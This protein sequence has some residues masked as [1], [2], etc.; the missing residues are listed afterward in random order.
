MH[1]LFLFIGLTIKSC[2]T[3]SKIS[4]QSNHNKSSCKDLVWHSF[5]GGKPD[6]FYLNSSQKILK[7]GD[8]KLFMSTET[9]QIL[10]R[11]GKKIF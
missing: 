7:D 1:I 9:V 4:K 3:T 10:K 8:L 5:I 2:S 6:K 11:K